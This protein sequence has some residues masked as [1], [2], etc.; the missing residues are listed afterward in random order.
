M[1]QAAP[2]NFTKVQAQAR[3]IVDA[4]NNEGTPHPTIARVSQ[5]VAMATVL[6]DTLPVPS[7]DGVSKVYH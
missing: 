6:L 7:T 3:A 1:E 2:I 5:D 4:I